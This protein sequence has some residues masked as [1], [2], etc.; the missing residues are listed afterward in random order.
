MIKLN[1]DGSS[2]SNSGRSGY[3]SLLRNSSRDWI[4]DFSERCG[5]TSNINVEHQTISH[6]LD[7]VWTHDY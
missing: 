7:L 2:I 1:V 6:G 4:F 5:F 3:G